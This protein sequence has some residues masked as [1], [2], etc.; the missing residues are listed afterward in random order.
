M[1]FFR[2][3]SVPVLLVCLSVSCR[4]PKPKAFKPRPSRR[5]NYEK[6]LPPG[7]MALEKITN[8]AEIPYFGK[9]FQD[10]KG[11][12]AA[13]QKSS[14]YFEK[15]SSKKYYPYLDI[16]HERAHQSL[17]AFQETLQA[18][19]SEKEFH[20]LLIERFDVYRSVGYNG[21]GT[22]FFTGYCEPIYEARLRPTAEYR[23]PLYKLPPDLVKDEEGTPLGRRTRSGE[24]V[25][26]FTRKQIET[27][28]LLK[29]LELVYLKSRLEAYIV[30]IQ[31]SARL[32]LRDG[33]EFRVGYAG[34]NDRPYRSIAMAL[35]KDGKMQKQELSLQTVKRYFANH[36]EDLDKYLHL[37]ESF[38]F[39]TQTRG[40]PYGSIGVAVTPYRSI[41][42][43]KAVFPRGCLTYVETHLP[44]LGGG[45][46]ESYHRPFTSFMLDQDTGGA[47]RSAGRADIFI[48][49]G[50]MAESLAGRV[51]SEGK[52]FYIFVKEGQPA[53]PQTGGLVKN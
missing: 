6:P 25:P 44:K 32:R 34:K 51:K 42:T 37:N 46:N 27:H 24:I 8:P 36:P 1:R 20:E 33:N 41:A 11:L 30:H 18:C 12:I 23:I 52:L 17:A 48:G 26:Y 39:F 35:I 28:N 5:P 16:T 4:S 10:R 9:A 13:L 38:V 50:P 21:K 40:G 29:G 15:P 19:Q 49:T 14:T 2:I 47:I 3:V 45:S 31:G 53:A 43:D 22:V 7:M